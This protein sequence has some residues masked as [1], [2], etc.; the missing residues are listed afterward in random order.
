M[1]INHWNEID[2]SP[3]A[4]YTPRRIISQNRRPSNRSAI[5]KFETAGK[6]GEEV[7]RIADVLS[8]W[9]IADNSFIPD[10]QTYHEAMPSIDHARWRKATLEEWNALLIGNTFE[11]LAQGTDAGNYEPITIPPD[12]KPI[13]SKWV[14]KVKLNPDGTKRYKVRLVI[15]G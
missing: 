15:K 5:Y 11:I 10:P 2:E 1:L 3:L 4:A 13:G 8:G 9:A 6:E 14:Y 12:I 7:N